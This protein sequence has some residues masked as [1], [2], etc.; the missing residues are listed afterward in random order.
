MR[1]QDA[2]P[3]VASLAKEHTTSHSPLGPKPLLFL[4][5]ELAFSNHKDDL[6]FFFKMLS[7]R[8]YGIEQQA[9]RLFTVGGR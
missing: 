3:P 9:P 8:A 1:P 4:L 6:S 5:C 2:T 7:R